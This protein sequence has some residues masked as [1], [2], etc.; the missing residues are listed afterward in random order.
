MNR[1]FVFAFSCTFLLVAGDNAF[2]QILNSL[3]YD[4]F[5][6]ERTNTGFVSPQQ[7]QDDVAAPDLFRRLGTG[8]VLSGYGPNEH[9]ATVAGR[10]SSSIGGG[11]QLKSYAGLE[12]SFES[13][14]IPAEPATMIDG[15]VIPGLPESIQSF[16]D[17]N[18]TV[19]AVSTY[20]AFVRPLD[21]NNN[22]VPGGSIFFD[23][24]VDGR[25]E[26]DLSSNGISVDNYASFARLESNLPL[27]DDPLDFISLEG[28]GSEQQQVDFVPQ[29]YNINFQ[30]DEEL[31]VEFTLTASV[32]AT[33]S[34]ST[35]SGSD[36]AEGKLISAFDNTANLTSIV[37]LDSNGEVV[38]GATIVTREG[39]VISAVTS[40]PEPS[41]AVCLLIASGTLL[42]RRKHI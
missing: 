3:E 40:V 10:T 1:I 2:G 21:A 26:L 17:F 9:V 33:I 22:F 12:F 4:V 5:Y 16:D 28:N 31:L 14:F 13:L 36:L 32:N 39:D 15:E 20:V 23:F 7:F 19:T 25:Q 34:N 38:P 27:L 18:A 41:S 35:L 8:S 11:L 6:T 42:L 37:V 30:E 24:A 29:G